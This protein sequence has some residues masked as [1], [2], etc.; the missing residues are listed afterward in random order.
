MELWQLLLIIGT[1]LATL[2]SF[3]W[4]ALKLGNV[5]NSE[6]QPRNVA[7]EAVDQAVGQAFSDD[8]REELRQRARQ[9]FDKIMHDNAMFLQQDIRVSAAHLDEFMKKEIYSTLQQ[10]LAKHSQSVTQTRQLL[11][12]SA[13]KSQADLQAQINAEKQQRIDQIDQRLAEIVQNY[14]S[15]AAGNVIT[16]EQQIALIIDNLNSRKIEIIEDIRRA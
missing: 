3:V 1:L 11:Y 9:Q 7:S 13:A 2:I 15:A 10:E 8:F 12:D 16:S 14:V 6:K 5:D 4:V